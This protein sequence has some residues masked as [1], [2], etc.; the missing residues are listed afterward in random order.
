MMMIKHDRK[1]S[2][3][4]IQ[5]VI[6]HYINYNDHDHVVCLF[7]VLVSRYNDVLLSVI[8]VHNNCKVSFTSK[9]KSLFLIAR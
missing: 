6:A 5:F 2:L 3:L 8:I 7:T 9:Y 4:I 1:S